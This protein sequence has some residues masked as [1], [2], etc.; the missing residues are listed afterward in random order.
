ML[1]AKF[2]HL[3]L[4]GTLLATGISLPVKSHAFFD[5]LKKS[6]ESLGG[7]L[8]AI[9]GQKTQADSGTQPLEGT[10]EAVCWMKFGPPYSG[11][12]PPGLSAEGLVAKYFHVTVDLGQ[13]LRDGISVIRLGAMP[14]MEHMLRDLND[15]EVERLGQAFV[16]SPTVINLGHIV[17]FSERGDTYK[18]GRRPSQQTEARTLL[19]L[20]LMQYPQLAKSPGQPAVI[21]RENYIRDSGLSTAM[22]ARMHLFGDGLPKDSSAFSNYLGQSSLHYPVHINDQTIFYA[23]EN[24]PNWNKAN[25]YRSFIQDSKKMQDALNRSQKA[26]SSAPAIRKRVL[27]IMAKVEESDGLI[28]EALG[29]GPTA[30]QMRARG[31]RMRKEASGEANLIAVSVTTSDEYKLEI[32]KLLLSSPKISDDAMKKI[33]KANQLRTQIANE[34]HDVAFQIARLFFN[35]NYAETLEIGGYFNAYFRNFCDSSIRSVQ[36]A[37]EAGVPPPTVQINRDEL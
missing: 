11:T 28:L 22:L 36:Y 25:F 26:S 2:T 9:P 33:A 1:S 14:N 24:L 37:K 27:T 17:N 15:R 20:V 18:E 6:M 8:G 34:M 29:A 13:K 4:V 32:R 16:R 7:Q 31:E 5:K 19:G 35:G 21:F 30:A 23:L 12:F 10:V 3:F